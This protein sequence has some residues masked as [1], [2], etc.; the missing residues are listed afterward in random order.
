MMMMLMLL[1][2][3][4]MMMMMTALCYS[5]EKIYA[6]NDFLKNLSLMTCRQSK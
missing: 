2:L 4:L 3:L 1:L 5:R 6:E